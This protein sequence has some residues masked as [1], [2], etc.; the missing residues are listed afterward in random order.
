VVGPVLG[1]RHVAN[2][3]VAVIHAAARPGRPHLQRRAV[4]V[5]GVDEQVALG[6]WQR[7]DARAEDLGED[8]GDA[9][10]LVAGMLE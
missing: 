9:L 10:G 6:V 1:E 7:D 4:A 8:G 3:E 5:A 2:V